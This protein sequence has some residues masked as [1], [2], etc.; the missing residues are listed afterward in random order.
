MRIRT[1]AMLAC[2]VVLLMACG[3]DKDSDKIN[4]VDKTLS[5]AESYKVSSEKEKETNTEENTE[6]VHIEK[7]LDGFYNCTQMEHSFTRVDFEIKSTEEGYVALFYAQYTTVNDYGE[8][9]LCTGVKNGDNTYEFTNDDCKYNVVWDGEDKLTVRG[10]EFAGIYER[11]VKDGYGE[12]D[13]AETDIMT[14]EPDE[15]VENGIE[16]D[17]TLAKVI[18]TELGYSEEHILTYQ[19]LEGVTY[20][21]AWNQ[22]IASIKGVSLLKN[23]EEI[24]INSGD[25]NDISEFAS[26]KNIRFIDITNCYIKEIPDLSTCTKLESLYL[27][28]N[29]ITDVTPVT[30][31]KSL[32]YVDLNNNIIRYISPLKEVES[33]DML[34]IDFNCI[35]DYSSIRDNAELIKAFDNGAQC[36]FE[37]ALSLENQVKEIVASFPK[38]LSELELE[39]IIYR[40]IKDNMYYDERTKNLA[41][42]G[43]YGIIKGWGVCGDY[44]GAFALIANHAGL[45]A[46]NC[47]SETHAWNIVKIDGV[48]YHCDALWD[49]DVDEWRY[50]NRSTG[51][52]Y[53]ISDHM[54]DI[55]RYPICEISMSKLEYLDCINK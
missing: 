18:R 26:L 21:A 46:Y 2:I 14:Y 42:Y 52:I 47:Y 41:P 35:L 19:D 25:I 36:T 45:E 27:A 37:Q 53:N 55:A 15:N 13:Y 33:L 7:K 44:S 12:G 20:L 30:K 6:N 51:Y 22:E 39:K 3:K 54:H 29:L 49:E 43:Y 38:G 50:F 8:E 34:S 5:S 16:I 10:D 31:I 11:G 28:S 9:L 48:Y 23:L 32:K 24:H 4:T 1:I 17:I 40:Y